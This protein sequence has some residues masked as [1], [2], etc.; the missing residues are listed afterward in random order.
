[1]KRILSPEFNPMSK[2]CPS[3]ASRSKI[4][5]MGFEVLNYIDFID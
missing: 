3:L 4:W 1:M 5:E 2:L